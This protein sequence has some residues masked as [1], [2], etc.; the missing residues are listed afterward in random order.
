MTSITEKKLPVS[1]IRR[2]LLSASIWANETQHGIR[3]AVTLSRRYRSA[4][5]TWQ[6]TKTLDRDSL[7]LAAEMLR[8]AASFVYGAEE[9][10]RHENQSTSPDL[11][12][13]ENSVNEADDVD[14]TNEI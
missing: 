10:R 3:Y 1:V 12:A 4:D 8:E 2:G 7:L 13:S 5:N 14:F 9:A 6:S 11:N